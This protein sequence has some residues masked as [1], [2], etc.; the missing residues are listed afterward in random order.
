MYPP[1]KKILIIYC[2]IHIVNCRYS[3]A[4]FSLTKKWD[5]DYGGTLD[6]L[7]WGLHKTEDRGFILNGSSTSNVGGNITQPN[8][9]MSYDMWI[10]KLDSSGLLQWQKRFGGTVQDRCQA[11]AEGNNHQYLY[12]GFTQSDVSGDVTQPKFTTAFDTDY[13]TLL[14]DSVGNKIWDRRFGGTQSDFL[15]CIAATL[16]GK[17]II[18]GSSLS[19][20]SGN[21]SENSRGL[22]DYWIVKI[23]SAGNKIW[24]KTFGGTL[25]E[26]MA[27]IAETGDKGFLLAGWSASGMGGDKTQIGYGDK[28]F[29]I[30]RIDSV[31]NKLWDKDYGGTGEDRMTT[32]TQL[33]NGEF[34]LA[35]YIGSPQGNDITEPPRGGY[36]LW[37]LKIDSMGNKIWDKRLGGTS[38]DDELGSVVSTFDGGFLISGTSYSDTGADKSENNLG[39]EQAWAIKLDSNGNKEWDKTIF[40]TGHDETAYAVQTEDS[41]YV[42]AVWSQGGIGGYKSQQNWCP[43][44]FSG[45]FWIIKFCDSASSTLSA[46]FTGVSMICPGTCTDFINL[47]QGAN[48]YLWL[49]P[50]SSVVSSSDANPVNICYNTPGSYDVTLISGDGNSYDTLIIPGYVTVYPSPPPQSIMQSGDTLIAIQG[51]VSYQWYY[52]GNMIPGATD[53]FYVAQ[54]SGDYNIVA[55]DSNG[56]EVE[57]VINDVIAQTDLTEKPPEAFLVWYNKESNTFSL[58]CRKGNSKVSISLFNSYGALVQSRN[59]I[60]EE[61]MEFS[62]TNAVSG[63]YLIRIESEDQLFVTKTIIYN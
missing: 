16:D 36:D 48:S 27:G 31:G 30:V 20:I 28:D 61:H 13:W 22:S 15:S 40:S 32:M 44:C 56:C 38:D 37:I 7:L 42:F 24:D 34:I 12:G 52:N 35:G 4:Q 33:S 21:K 25:Q 50:G 10:A 58:K 1:V 2:I 57:A 49:F 3:Q 53:Y 46:A 47:S 23:D 14:S 55:A 17:Y 41:C 45:D 63:L 62:L 54:V 5:Y 11:L 43:G 6:E 51:A 9:G 60:C 18:G 8:W 39:V 26:D 19:D 59:A 29:W